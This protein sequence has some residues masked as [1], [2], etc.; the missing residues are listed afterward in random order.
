[1]TKVIVRDDNFERAIRKF[2]KKVSDSGKFQTLREK[3]FYE[4]PTTKRKKAANAARNRWRKK[5]EAEQ[6]PEKPY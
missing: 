1:M 2:K 6:L 4:K 5:L 3:E